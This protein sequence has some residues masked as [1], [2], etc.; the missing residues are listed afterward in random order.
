MVSKIKNYQNRFYV[1]RS[2]GR[3]GTATGGTKVED[4]YTL[5]K[6]LSSFNFIYFDKTGTSLMKCPL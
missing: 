3:V 2:W 5:E 6:A 1:F 4:F